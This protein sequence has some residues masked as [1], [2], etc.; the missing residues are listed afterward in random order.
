MGQLWRPDE[1]LGEK[2]L[3]LPGITPDN[4]KLDGAIKSAMITSDVFNICERLKELNPR[5]EV[6]AIWDDRP[7]GDRGYAIMERVAP[8]ETK[9]VFKCRELD[10]R[11]IHEVQYLIGVPFSER[12]AR[13][14]KLLADE[15]RRQKEAE[16]D[17]LYENLGRQMLRQFEHDGF[18]ESRGVSFPK[19]GVRPRD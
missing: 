12:M 5:L 15:D 2:D 7:G 17:E 3:V 6:H 8:D 18:I 1:F 19:R 10:A 14:E 4:L 13:V 9:L 16:L 11:V